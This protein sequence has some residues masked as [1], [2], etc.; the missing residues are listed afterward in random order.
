MLPASRLQALWIIFHFTAAAGLV[1][2]ANWLGLIAWRRN[3]EAHWTER[4]RLLWPARI[5][6]GTNI[7]LV[8][9]IVHFSHRLLAAKASDWWLAEG[10]AA[11]MGG[12]LGTFPFDREV[13]PQLS[14][15][16]WRRQ[17]CLGWG[18]RIGLWVGLVA[19]ILLM[20]NEAGWL[21]LAIAASYLAFHLSLQWGLMLFLL[22]RIGFLVPA[23]ER[24][25]RLVGEVSDRM[26]IPVPGVWSFG[27]VQALAF[28]MPTTRELLFSERLMEISSDEELAAICS[29]ELGHLT[30]SK[31]TLAGRVVGSLSFYPLIFLNPAANLLPPFGVFL[32]LIGMMVIS[33]FAA[34]LSQKMEKRADTLAISQQAEEGMYAR[35]LEKIYRENHLPA[36]NPTSR[37]THPHLFD[38]MLAAGITPDYPRPKPP[39]K[40][41]WVGVIVWAGFGCLLIA[42]MLN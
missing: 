9:V 23:N 8:P 42:G 24:L 35:A 41:T 31:A 36:V 19:A 14:F 26:S 30:E 38:R 1:S 3:R 12:L 16:A 40:L 17:A 11:L 37:G 6:A 28:A 18:L 27:G 13:F 39:A 10:F 15:R 33:R 7:F 29:H 34:W 2:L 20:P 4:A 22:R 25:R 32:P 21:M 5:A